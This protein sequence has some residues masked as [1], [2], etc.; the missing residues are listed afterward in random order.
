MGENLIFLYLTWLVTTI[1]AGKKSNKKRTNIT[2]SPWYY[3][4]IIHFIFYVLLSFP[5]ITL[6]LKGLQE[7]EYIASILICSPFIIYPLH[8]AIRLLIGYI[9]NKNITL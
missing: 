9:N 2:A 7:R 3:P 4:H 5:G 8:R 6:L 1:L